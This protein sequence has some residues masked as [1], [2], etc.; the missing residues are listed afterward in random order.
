MTK[1]F[2]DDTVVISWTFIWCPFCYFAATSSTRKRHLQEE[3]EPINSCQSPLKKLRNKDDFVCQCGRVFDNSH[4]LATH[5]QA[6][7][8]SLNK[9]T[10][11]GEFVCQCGR[12]FN[13][14]HNLA[15]H[16]KSCSGDATFPFLCSMCDRSFETNRQRKRHQ[17]TCTPANW[18]DSMF[19]WNNGN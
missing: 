19:H 9:L 18:T 14:S 7:Q 2:Q 6:C 8:S 12:A 10:K 17:E 3:P 1:H 11:K 16:E 4:N 13:N 5:E 15:A